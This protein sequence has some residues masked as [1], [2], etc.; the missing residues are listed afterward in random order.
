MITKFRWP[1]L[2]QLTADFAEFKIRRKL[3]RI[4]DIKGFFRPEW[5]AIAIVPNRLVYITSVFHLRAVSQMVRLVASFFGLT[6]IHLN[7]QKKQAA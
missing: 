4:D 3:F 2:K 1:L 6:A 5:A 7:G